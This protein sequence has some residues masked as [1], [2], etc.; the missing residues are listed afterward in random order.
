MTKVQKMFE[1]SNYLILALLII[2]QSTV[3]SMFY[4]GQSIYLSANILSITRCWVLDR[5]TAD[6]VKDCCMFGITCGLI[7]IKIFGGF[8][9]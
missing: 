4:V 1:I 8:H 7:L 6:K 2:G 9:S 3:G 5:P